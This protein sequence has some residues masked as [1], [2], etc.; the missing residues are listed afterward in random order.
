LRANALRRENTGPTLPQRDRADK[1][2]T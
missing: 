1:R 2:E